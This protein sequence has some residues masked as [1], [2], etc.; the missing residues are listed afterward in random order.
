MSDPAIQE[1][2]ELMLEMR[3]DLKQVHS[4]IHRME[5]TLRADNQR[6]EQTLRAEIEALKTDNQRIESTLRAEMSEMRETLSADNRRI[7]EKLDARVDG[8]EKRLVN[9]EVISRTAF[10]AVVGGTF[11]GLIKFLFFPSNP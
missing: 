9:Q 10:I 5:D 8:L 1:L 2:K 3:G 6:I 4:E 7:E 11:T